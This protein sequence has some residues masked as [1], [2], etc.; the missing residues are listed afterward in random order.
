[1]DTIK[2]LITEDHTL[3]R[4]GLKRLFS[5]VPGIAIAGE[6]TTGAEAMERLAQGGVDLLLLDLTL[7][8]RCGEELVAHIHACHPSLPILILTMHNEVQIAQRALLAGARGYVTKDCDPTTLLGAVREVASGRRFLD[9]DIAQRMAFD[10]SGIRDD[11]GHEILSA[12]ELQI[13]RMLADGQGVNEIAKQLAISNKTVSTHK[14]RLMEKMHF[15]SNAD[16]V[17]Y[18]LA[19][20]LS[21]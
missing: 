9:P 18:A 20:K 10:A 13:L 14:A 12:R 6:A 16:I 19:N 2:V 3:I 7:P 4:E 1:M 21:Q 11:I 17:K 8:G 5:L 15:A